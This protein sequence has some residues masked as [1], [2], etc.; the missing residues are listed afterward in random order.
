MCCFTVCL[1]S[2]EHPGLNRATFNSAVADMKLNSIPLLQK[3]GE[4]ASKE[5]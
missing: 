1:F 3:A 4:K 5:S 2:L